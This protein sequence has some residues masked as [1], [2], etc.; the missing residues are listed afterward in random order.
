MICPVGSATI[1][2]ESVSGW[3]IEFSW[4]RWQGQSSSFGVSLSVELEFPSDEVVEIRV[5]GAHRHT[6]LDAR[7]SKPVPSL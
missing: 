5:I 6:R 7:S 4:I 2:S 1:G 3:G